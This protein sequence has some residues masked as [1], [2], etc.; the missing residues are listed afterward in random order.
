MR[1]HV[2]NSLRNSMVMLFCAS[3]SLGLVMACSDDN[4]SSRAQIRQSRNTHNGQES[5][6]PGTPDDNDLNTIASSFAPEAVATIAFSTYQKL[7]RAIDIIFHQEKASSLVT[8]NGCQ[9]VENNKKEQ[10]NSSFTVVTNYSKCAAQDNN[11]QKWQG[12]ENVNLEHDSKGIIRT[13]SLN[14]RGVPLILNYRNQRIKFSQH[15][16]NITHKEDNIY[17]YEQ[18]IALEIESIQ[19]STV[20]TYATIHSAGILQLDQQNRI[21]TVTP[22]HLELRDLTKAASGRKF[23]STRMIFEKTDK[24]TQLVP[25]ACGRPLADWTVRQLLEKK[26]KST[27]EKEFLLTS[28]AQA[29]TLKGSNR[30]MR[31]EKCGKGFT[32]L[33]ADLIS[34]VY[35]IQKSLGR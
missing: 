28:S 35:E 22:S 5:N 21:K 18:D 11:N 31:L 23:A 29:V 24:S 20:Q 33:Q 30:S 26:N 19:N 8:A 2:L 13:A 14:V 25:L 1:N 10:K 17:E 34:A 3:V 16:L 32:A 15:L 27:D 4:S 7:S 12:E 6:K 9:T